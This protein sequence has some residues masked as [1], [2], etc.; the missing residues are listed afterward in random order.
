MKKIIAG[1][2]ALVVLCGIFFSVIHPIWLKAGS[3]IFCYTSD[4]YTESFKLW[5]KAKIVLLFLKKKLKPP[6]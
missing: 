5:K 3:D 2:I 1:L 4:S 6:S